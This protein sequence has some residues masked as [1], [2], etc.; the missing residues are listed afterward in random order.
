MSSLKKIPSTEPNFFYC[1]TCKDIP[2]L[3]LTKEDLYVDVSYNCCQQILHETLVRSEKISLLNF[4]NKLKDHPVPPNCF[5]K[6]KH[7]NAQTKA[8]AY[9]TDCKKFLCVSC[10]VEHNEM[11]VG[12]CVIFINNGMIPNNECQKNDCP[13]KGK[14]KYFCKKCQIHLCSECAFR[15]QNG[16]EMIDLKE[17]IPDKKYEEYCE[18]IEKCDKQMKKFYSELLVVLKNL[19]NFIF[20]VKLDIEK[21]Q[22]EDESILFFFESLV[23]TSNTHQNIF[24]YNVKN[25]I[26]ENHIDEIFAYRR[27]QLI[28]QIKDD[29]DKISFSKLLKDELKLPAF[30]EEFIVFP[31]LYDDDELRFEWK[32]G[33][34]YSVSNNGLS[35]TKT[36]NLNRWDCA[37]IGNKS[38]IPNKLNKWKIKLANFEHHSGNYW[39][40]A[41]GIGPAD[42][43]Q[44]KFDLYK[45]CWVVICYTSKCWFVD[46]YGPYLVN[47]KAYMM[48]T[49]DVIGI[50]VDLTVKTL[51]FN[52]NNGK[53]V[54][55]NYQIPN[56]ISLVPVV[57][58]T[59]SKESVDIIPFKST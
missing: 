53:F 30:T 5:K 49:G 38:L 39:D 31:R 22:K 36:G 58:I 57:L 55:V 40:I 43:D 44:T 4:N 28:V 59:D 27:A 50:I 25:N 10:L 35:A 34:N 29:F 8:K 52:I 46:T 41:I 45:K 26:K 51:A 15:H 47:N 23:L 42:I 2:T 17:M 3:S 18:N 16:H 56:D 7:K 19:E 12:H 1:S 11:V 9:C 37:I 48:K 14:K 32:E 13:N 20:Q 6:N 33:P 21:M 24:S 54:V